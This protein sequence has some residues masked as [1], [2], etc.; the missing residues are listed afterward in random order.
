MLAATDDVEGGVG[1]S[2]W[3]MGHFD[4]WESR[5]AKSG[6]NL[7][8]RLRGDNAS[9]KP[10]AEDGEEP[11]AA[12]GLAEAAAEIAGEDDAALRM[13]TIGQATCRRRRGAGDP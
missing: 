11:A 3:A 2:D 5:I 12:E 7:D 6:G 13:A 9:V 1:G 8:N 10:D 4:C